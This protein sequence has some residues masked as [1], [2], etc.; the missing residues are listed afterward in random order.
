MKLKK[1]DLHL[2]RNDEY[3]QFMSEMNKL[4][5]EFTTETLGIVVQ[6]AQ[7][8]V[9]LNDVESAMKVE[10]GSSQTKLITDADAYRDQLDQG[11]EL[12]VESYS[13]HW[14][15]AVTEAARRIGRIISQYGNLRKLSYNEESSAIANKVQELTS[16]TYAPDLELMNLTV[17]T[18]K[19]LDANN[20]FIA[21]FSDRANEEASRASS[22]VRKARAVLDPTYTSIV[23]R[24]NALIEINGEEAYSAFV[25]KANYYTDYYKTTITA[26]KSR[27][28][29]D[30]KAETAT[31]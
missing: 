15:Q 21:T 24:I 27:N 6:Y 26:R 16:A 18:G 31:K 4:F 22:N 14:D 29:K 2:F 12:Q 3:D 5:V 9:Q 1:I 20:A 11:L 17:W 7:F 30:K 25:D 28:A 23:N 13:Y 8:K 10:S 19:L